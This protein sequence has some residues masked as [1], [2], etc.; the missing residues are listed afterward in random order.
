MNKN[1]KKFHMTFQ[2][3]ITCVFMPVMLFI[4]IL[5]GVL[6]FRFVE[7]DQEQLL[8]NSTD[9]AVRLTLEYLDSRL[10]NAV[11]AIMDI[12][13]SSA[14]NAVIKDIED[15]GD[16]TPSSYIEMQNML[17]MSFSKNYSYL[18]SMAVSFSGSNDVFYQG[19]YPI[20]AIAADSIP[21]LKSGSYA[22]KWICPS[23]N[24]P[25][26]QNGMEHKGPS[27]CLFGKSRMGTEFAVY[28]DFYH[29]LIDDAVKNLYA[30]IADSVVI[31]DGTETASYGND[32]IERYSQLLSS[33]IYSG[34]YSGV[35]RDN[36]SIIVYDSLSLNNWRIAVCIDKHS[37]LQS[38]DAMRN[39]TITLVV[40]CSLLS[41]GLAIL[42]G[43]LISKPI[44][45]FAQRVRSINADELQSGCFSDISSI[46][47]EINVLAENME[48]LAERVRNLIADTEK[49]QAENARMQNSLLL[50][51]INPHFLYNTLYAIAQECEMGAN[52]EA[53]EMLYD[54][55]AFFRIGL[56]SGK[57]LLSISEECIHVESYLKI[58]K[59]SFPYKLSY[60]ISVDPDISGFHIPKMT[61]QPI[62]ENCFKHGLRNKRS[63][64]SIMIMAE[65]LPDSIR[66]TVSDDGCGMDKDQLKALNNQI[67]S[68]M[69]KEKGFGMINV[70]QRL[71]YYF[72]DRCSV[73]VLSEK[74]K[75]TDVLIVIN[76]SNMEVV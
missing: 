50:A 31:I 20:T 34:N 10:Y 57:E 37:V 38:L 15:T 4:V 35:A 40:L 53:E 11:A 68:D 36:D 12:Y 25:I 5:T 7:R 45:A 27:L 23:E 54:L 32:E 63:D 52:K 19:F 43:W 33:V 74:E 46:S 28:L 69:V 24:S 59:R 47:P 66:I 14:V 42:F 60:I 9:N 17:S 67:H 75:G 72:G 73:N 16:I 55:S 1:K 48:S 51:Q 3:M 58:I 71:H 62:V 44:N 26:M 8:I 6:S 64:G 61:L 21:Y 49:K 18:S 70:S 2:M 29:M 30:S 22:L 76:N 41:I 65:R 39:I 13:N 56:N